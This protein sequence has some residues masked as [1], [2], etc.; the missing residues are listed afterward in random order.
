[1]FLNKDKHFGVVTF[2]EGL[3]L[4]KHERKTGQDQQLKMLRK[5]LNIFFNTLINIICF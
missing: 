3:L 1:M 2:Q 5:M 4:L